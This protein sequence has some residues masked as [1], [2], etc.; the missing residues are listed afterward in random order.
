MTFPRIWLIAVTAV[1]ALLGLQINL[2]N[3]GNNLIPRNFVG[4]AGIVLS[5]AGVMAWRLRQGDM[6][7]PV[8]GLAWLIP[9][10]AILIHALIVPVSIPHYPVTAAGMLVAF[11]FWL[12]ALGQVDFGPADWYAIARL[13]W[14]GSMVLVVFAL[15]TENYLNM[16]P[17]LDHLWLVLRLP[18]GGFQQRNLFAS[19]IAAALMW[20]WL[21]RLKVQPDSTRLGFMAF[22]LSVF[23]GAWVVLLSGSRTGSVALLVSVVGA[24]IYGW[25][26]KVRRR[27]WAGAG[28]ALFNGRDGEWFAT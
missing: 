7:W 22:Y 3:L 15:P 11:A 21:L 16:T 10:V 13:I 9:P 6:R 18:E 5:A 24:V 25:P 17:L 20:V 1:I 4:W 12:W 27:E 28:V 14:A 19:F 2:P 26:L 23:L 8:L